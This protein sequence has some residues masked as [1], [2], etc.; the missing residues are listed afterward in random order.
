MADA[1]EWIIKHKFS[2]QTLLHYLDDFLNVANQNHSSAQCQ[3]DIILEVF[4]YLG[5]PIAEEKIEGPNQNL[6]FLGIELDGHFAS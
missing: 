4:L 5:I 3:L 6:I 2:I 1:V